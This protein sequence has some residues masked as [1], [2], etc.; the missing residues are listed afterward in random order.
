MNL[1]VDLILVN[2]Q[3]SASLISRKMLIRLGSVVGPL[4]LLTLIA[5]QIASYLRVRADTAM[6]EDAWKALEPRQKAALQYAAAFQA[7]GAIQKELE[8]WKKSHINWHEQLIALIRETPRNIQL[9]ALSLSQV[10]QLV[11]NGK[12]PARAFSMVLKGKAVGDQAEQNVQEFNRKLMTAASFGG[13]TTNAEVQQFGADTSKDAGKQ[14]RVFQI[15]CR[16]RER[17][18][19]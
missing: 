5:M 6:K 16:Y 17:K 9:Q 4:L 3:R 13:A 14:D 15:L 7:N 8:G 2:E 10:L 19:E 18:F 1:R 12:T 11:D